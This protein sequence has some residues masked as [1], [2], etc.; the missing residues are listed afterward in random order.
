MIIKKLSELEGKEALDFL[1]KNKTAALKE[2]KASFKAAQDGVYFTPVKTTATKNEGCEN[3]YE[4]VGNSINF[5]D[6]HSDVSIRGS[7][8]KTVQENGS[9]VYILN[10]HQHDPKSIIAENKGVYVTDKSIRD[11][12][13]DSNGTTQVLAAKINV[14]DEVMQQR[15]ADGQIK[16]HSVGIRYVK[17]NLAINDP[18][19]EK[20]FAVWNKYRPDII[21]GELADQKGFFWAVE[22]QQLM[23]ISAV[24][25]GSNP[26]TPTTTSTKSL[27]EELN[28]LKEAIK[29]LREDKSRV[30][31]HKPEPID[32]VQ[33]LN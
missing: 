27:Q 28:E 32:W 25:W 11:L 22:E 1:K 24:L 17:I 23:E 16:Q 13:H 31:T 18:S 7:F 6:S 29:S 14:T 3:E 10:N 26:Y 9:A 8:N 30:S 15:Y 19:E 12:G 33:Y 21:N 4:I 5:M 2:K 20:E